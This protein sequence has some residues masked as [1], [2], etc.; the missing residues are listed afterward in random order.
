MKD[1]QERS[2]ARATPAPR[3][4]KLETDRFLSIPGALRSGAIGDLA[5]SAVVLLGHPDTVGPFLGE[6]AFV[7]DQAALQVPAQTLIG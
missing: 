4:E 3:I 1:A 5:Q 2:K 7:Q 6:G